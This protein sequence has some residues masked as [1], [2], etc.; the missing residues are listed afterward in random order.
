MRT[1]IALLSVLFLLESACDDGSGKKN[2][3]NNNTNNTNNVNNT[4]NTNN[5]NN[6]Y[7]GDGR[8]LGSE[9]CDDGNRFSG[10]GCSAECLWEYECGDNV[11]EFTEECDGE[12]FGKTTCVT[13]GHIGGTL[14]CTPTCTVD[15]SACVDADENL[16]GWYKMES[17]TVQE[18]NAAG[19]DNICLIRSIGAGATIQGMPGR[20]GTTIFFDSSSNGDLR[21]YMDCGPGYAGYGQFTAETWIQ[22]TLVGMNLSMILSSVESYDA[23][24]LSFYMALTPDFTLEASVG[25]WESPLE[26]T[27]SVPTGSWHHVAMTWDGTTLSL[28]VDGMAAGSATSAYSGPIPALSDARF[29]VASNYLTGGQAEN[30]HFFNGYIDEIKIWDAARTR[31]EICEDAGGV[32]TAQGWSL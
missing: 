28:F 32:P 4:N 23:T 24:G 7:C 29:Y 22:A 16:R 21:A 13:L 12:D 14:S 3:A 8:V 10:D 20:I 17:M 6:G 30:G 9:E 27:L 15:A 18:P 19:D 25:D 11:R 26:S 2:N 1:F 5:V 31:E